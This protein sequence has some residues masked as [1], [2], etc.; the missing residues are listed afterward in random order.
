MGSNVPPL[1]IFCFAFSVAPL[2]L[3][4][5]LLI[6][7]KYILVKYIQDLMQSYEKG[8]TTKPNPFLSSWPLAGR[9]THHRPI[10]TL[11]EN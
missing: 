9:I 10:K 6:L 2:Q 8:G 11:E 5:Y 4:C 1:Y 3:P 7:D